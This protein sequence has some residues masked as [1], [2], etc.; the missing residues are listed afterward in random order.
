MN[1]QDFCIVSLIPINW[2]IMYSLSNLCLNLVSKDLVKQT[3]VIVKE[4]NIF[5]MKHSYSAILDFRY[6]FYILLIVANRKTEEKFNLCMTTLIL[7]KI[8]QP[9]LAYI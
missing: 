3:F 2:T 9:R 7:H 6:F 8:I 5:S 1:F 4:K